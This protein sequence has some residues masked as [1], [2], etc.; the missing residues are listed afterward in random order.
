[1]R[2]GLRVNS[3]SIFE[4]LTDDYGI[5]YIHEEI[6][7]NLEIMTDY[8]EPSSKKSL[9]IYQTVWLNKKSYKPGDLVMVEIKNVRAF[10]L[11]GAPVT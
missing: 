3:P 2:S 7:Y 11:S 6:P 1:M 4:E 5:D 10:S 9:K 8:I